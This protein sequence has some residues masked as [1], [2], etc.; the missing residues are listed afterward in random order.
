MYN[1]MEDKN[2][3][4]LDRSEIGLLGSLV[5]LGWAFTSAWVP[6]LA[7]LKGRKP[8]VLVSLLIE[9]PAMVLI[10]LTKNYYVLATCFFII[11]ACNTG[12]LLVGFIYS[13][14]LVEE[15]YVK[16]AGTIL[17]VFHGLVYLKPLFSSI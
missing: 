4:C 6:R 9:L 16:K 3:R 17:T 5:F 12:S 7:D 10:L 11:G 8:I 1:F 14:E 2:L 15:K 13:M